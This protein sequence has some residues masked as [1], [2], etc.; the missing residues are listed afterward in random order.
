M[1]IQYLEYSNKPKVTGNKKLLQADGG[2]FKVYFQTSSAS[3]N[4]LVCGEH[5]F[6]LRWLCPTGLYF[7]KAIHPKLNN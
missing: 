1:T 6:F 2:K 3:S 5:I 7:R 4:S